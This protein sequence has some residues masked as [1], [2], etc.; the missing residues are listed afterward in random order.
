MRMWVRPL[1]LLSGLRIRCCHELWRRSQAPLGSGV[2]VAPIRSLAWEPPYAAG[3][4][5]KS[6]KGSIS[7]CSSP[8]TVPHSPLGFHLDTFEDY[9]LVILQNV[10]RCGLVWYFLMV[11]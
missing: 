2:A 11:P 6:K 10:S 9:T 3:A 1:A 8:L 4:A 5:L 7:V